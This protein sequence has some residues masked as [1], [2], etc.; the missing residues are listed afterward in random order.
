M[1]ADWAVFFTV[2]VRAFSSPNSLPAT[3]S[4]ECYFKRMGEPSLSRLIA[5]WAVFEYTVGA[6]AFSSPNSL[7]ATL[8]Q[9]CYY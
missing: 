8:S 9:K 2:G 1:L 3:L 7:P 4:Q 5:Y 6:R